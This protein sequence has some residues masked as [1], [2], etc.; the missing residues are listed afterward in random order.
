M[1]ETEQRDHGQR[2]SAE[3]QD[4]AEGNGVKLQWVDD[5]LRI[6]SADALA[7]AVLCFPPGFRQEFAS[8]SAYRQ[9]EAIAAMVSD[10]FCQFDAGWAGVDPKQIDIPMSY[11]RGAD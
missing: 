2:L 9:E 3:L 7:R 5:T 6:V 4:W 8:A 11:V 10:V 1:N